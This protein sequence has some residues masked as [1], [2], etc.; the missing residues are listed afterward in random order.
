MT[1]HPGKKLLFMGGEFAQWSEWHYEGWLDWHLLPNP[2]TPFPLREGGT[3]GHVPSDGPEHEQL[4]RLVRDLNTM[5]RGNPALYQRDFSP[6]GFAW[7]DGSD[8][9]H[10]VIAFL[11][12]GANHSDPLL[13]VTNFTPVPRY[14]YRVGVPSA[15]FWEEALNTDAAIYGGSNLGNLGGVESEPVAWHGREQSV[16]LTLPPLSVLALR[17]RRPNRLPP[18]REGKGQQGEGAADR[19]KRKGRTGS[20][21]GAKPEI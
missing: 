18:S 3:Q 2:L 10:S 5:V 15:G 21:R 4:R 16:Q 13:F 11:R 12:Y 1:A 7:I 19:R 9:Q 8:A 20:Q 6:E 14:E 17:P